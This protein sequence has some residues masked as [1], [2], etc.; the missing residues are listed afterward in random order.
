MSE[1]EPTTE[2]IMA[3]VRRMIETGLR[4]VQN[5]VEL[6]ALEL[7]EEKAWLISTLLWAAAAVFFGGLAIIFV[8]VTVVYLSPE[9]ARPWV[10][11]GFALLFVYLAV[12]AIVGLR[13]SMENKKAPM[14]DTIGE[15][16]K[17]IEWIQSR[18]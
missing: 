5:R 4:S 13:R 18:D 16:K 3:S 14:S 6:F 1:N 7:Q 10:L 15:L 12:N 11:G 8:V 17:D 2:G 9:N